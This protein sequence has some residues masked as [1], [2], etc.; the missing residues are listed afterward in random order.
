MELDKPQIIAQSFIESIDAELRPTNSLLIKVSNFNSLEFT[1]AKKQLSGLGWEEGISEK[2]DYDF[3]VVDLPI[4]MMK[5]KSSIGGHELSIKQNWHELIKALRMLKETG[6]C[7]ALVEPTAFAY[8]V[9][10]KFTNALEEDGYFL[11]ALLDLP[12]KILQPQTSIRP[13][14][15]IFGTQPKDSLFVGE[16]TNLEQA[17]RLAKSFLFSAVGEG[18]SEGMFIKNEQ[19]VGFKNL[20]FKQQLAKLKTQYKTYNTVPFKD[21]VENVKAVR[22][23]DVFTDAPNA[24][25]VPKL[26]A[27]EVTPDIEKLT[28][29]HHNI[30]QI[31]LTDRVS[32]EFVSA[33]FN[34]ELGKLIIGSC[35]VGD[36]IE[37]LN[38]NLLLEAEIALPELKEQEKIANTHKKLSSLTQAIISFQKE[39][40]LNPT[41]AEAI[42][43]QLEGMLEQIGELSDADRA[44]SMIRSGESKTI[45]FKESFC[46]DVRKGTKES[47]IEVSALKTIVAFL[48][49]DGGTLLIGV[50]DDGKVPGINF[51]V[52]KL[53]KNNDK[54]LLHFKNLLTHKIGEQYYPFINQKLIMV[55]GEPV[56]MVECKPCPEPCYL[57]QKDFYVRTNPATDKLE[58]PKLVKYVENHF[59]KS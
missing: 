48:N 13:V 36:V 58:G 27:S 31:Q 23:G 20:R 50:S 46:L 47:Y 22:S 28:I 24:I 51:E 5:V 57:D 35:R 30:L 6:I 21:I 34:S 29:K 54:F 25:Y 3:I 49:T 53:F 41:S 55:L 16:I 14:L 2:K 45:E 39:L 59:R 1:N 11:Q 17:S 8:D 12:E 42:N 40:A 43:I 19:F 44:M 18:L 15:A 56:F 26:G 52:D 38:K 33:F 32:N 9:G 7:L 10:D 37:R 4:G